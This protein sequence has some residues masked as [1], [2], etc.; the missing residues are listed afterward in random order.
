MP[1]PC[2]ALSCAQQLASAASRPPRS[3]ACHNDA[4][5]ARRQPV[6]APRRLRL[7][8]RLPPPAALRAVESFNH[9]FDLDEQQQQKLDELLYSDLFCQQARRWR[10]RNHVCHCL[11]PATEL[12]PAT[13][14]LLRLTSTLHLT[15]TPTPSLQV[16]RDCKLPEGTQVEFTGIL[17]Q[18]VPW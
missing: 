18:P 15:P 16:A 9:D 8:R 1:P 13:L 2:L 11:L 4:A 12:R 5:A 6:A 17:F 3:T 10:R 7:P 14:C